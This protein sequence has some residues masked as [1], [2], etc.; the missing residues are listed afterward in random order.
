MILSAYDKRGEAKLFKDLEQIR[1]FRRP[2]KKTYTPSRGVSSQK[3]V[4]ESI[5][6]MQPK[7]EV[8][9]T[10]IRF[11]LRGIKTGVR[12]IAPR[13]VPYVGWALTGKDIYDFIT[14]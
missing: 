6:I 3:P 9:P 4:S 2:S 7:F 1:G 12:K 10:I 14:D 5:T 11:G 13:F 8:D